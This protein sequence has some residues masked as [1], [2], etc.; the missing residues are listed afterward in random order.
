MKPAPNRGGELSGNGR[1]QTPVPIAYTAFFQDESEIMSRRLLLKAMAAL[2]GWLAFA[3]GVFGRTLPR[4]AAVPGGVAI[5]PLGASSEPPVAHLKARRL[6]V[7]GDAAQWNAIV[8]IALSTKEG[9][10]LRIGVERPD[11]TNDEVPVVVGTK[12]YATQELTVKPGQVNLSEENLAR[13]RRESAH[14]KKIRR[15]FSEAPPDSLSLM[16]PCEGVR[17]SSFGLRR[18]FNGES[19]NPHSGMDLAAPEGAPVLATAAGRVIDRGDYF[20]S[21][22]MII[23]DHGQ[24]LLTLYAHLSA[25]DVHVGEQVERGAQIGRVSA[26]GRVTGAHLHFGVYLNSVP[27]DP[28]LFLG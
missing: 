27:V 16:Q 20:F 28:A 2:S 15:T 17:S 14:L 3:G 9:S 24:G 10:T 1:I 12:R 4:A 25:M 5:V 22:N 8:G 18:V 7:A 23:L 13:Y 6:M 26:T 11:G 21:G 19:R